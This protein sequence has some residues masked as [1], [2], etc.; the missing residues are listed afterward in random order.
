MAPHFTRTV[1]LL[2]LSLALA[3]GSAL[4]ER[5]DRL[6]P[7]NIEADRLQY[8]DANQVSVF[9]G[10]VVVTQG[11]L[12]LRGQQLD[13]RQDAQGHQRGVLTGSP[14]QRAFFRQQRTGLDEFVEGEAV[15]IDYDSLADTLTLTGQAVLRRFRGTT[16][17]DETQGSRIIYNG[18]L[19]TFS[20]EGGAAGRSAAN[21]AGRVRALLSPTPAPEATPS[22]APSAAPAPQAPRPALT[23]SQRLEQRP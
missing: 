8:D 7:M 5:A 13:V 6:A 23:P 17:S 11:S 21:P 20:V 19:E 12:I 1:R 4:A 2:L 3:C 15:R 18:A 9:S 14:T 22:T 16:L 10:N